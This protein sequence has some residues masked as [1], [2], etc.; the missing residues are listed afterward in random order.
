MQFAVCAFDCVA[1]SSVGPAS[2]CPPQQESR[3]CAGACRS[4]VFSAL[5]AASLDSLSRATA[6][7]A[8]ENL[9]QTCREPLRAAVAEVLN[10]QNPGRITVSML[11]SD[12]STSRHFHKV[13]FFVNPDPKLPANIMT[14]DPA[15][16]A[17][18]TL[19]ALKAAVETRESVLAQALSQCLPKDELVDVLVAPVDLISAD[20]LY[21]TRRNVCQ[22]WPETSPHGCECDV[23]P[24]SAWSA[25]DIRC[26][27]NRST[28]TRSI[29]PGAGA[30]SCPALS[31][32]RECES[33]CMP[34]TVT[35]PSNSATT[36]EQELEATLQACSAEI[37][38]KIVKII[39]VPEDRVV[40]SVHSVQ[41]GKHQWKI[42]LLLARGESTVHL[43][44]T[45][46]AISLQ[47]R[48]THSELNQL[49]LDCLGV[50]KLPNAQDNFSIREMIVPEM[51]SL[52]P[53]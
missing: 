29:E 52:C 6:A 34:M 26:V 4:F 40:S 32:Q 42:A 37:H 23:T 14:A 39:G 22:I 27:D 11:N 41:N 12:W 53:A 25:C 24:W 31:E 18:H 16:H 5:A 20:K 1:Q 30:S 9:F 19:E 38:T 46:G 49:F 8:A 36:K 43:T 3:P 15:A 47:L 45:L 17:T 10:I 7:I 21:D 13:E 44:S 50:A 48:T 35:Y 51:A 2:G 33:S 28:R